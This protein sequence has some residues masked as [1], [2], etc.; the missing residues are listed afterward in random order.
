MRSHP[1]T[2]PLAG[3]TGVNFGDTLSTLSGR[4]YVDTNNNGTYDGT[5]VALSGVTV[6]LTMPDAT[7]V[8]KLST[9]DGSYSFTD[10]PSGTYGVGETQPLGYIDSTDYA[11]TFAGTV[12]NDAITAVAV[13]AGAAGTG[14]DFTE[15]GAAISGTVYV[16]LNRDGVIDA[17]DH[18]IPV[19]ITL[20]PSGSANNNFGGLQRR[21]RDHRHR[22]RYR[23][24]TRHG[25]GSGYRTCN[26]LH[27]AQLR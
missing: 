1:V 21:S 26:R 6:T 17:A 12:A 25:V 11:G 2:L 15:K 10:L 9:S 4:T 27:H 13:T 20:S 16:D 24:L 8:T 19:A 7:T 3:V 22:W 5:D 23:G 14:Y 18:V